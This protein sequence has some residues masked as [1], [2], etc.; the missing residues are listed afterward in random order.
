MPEITRRTFVKGSAVAVGGTAI[1]SKFLFGGL[2]TVQ[3]TN[4]LLMAQQ[5]QEDFVN[6]T[7]WIGKQDC[8]IVARRVNGRL[9]SLEGLEA[10]PKNRGTLC[11]KGTAQIAAVYDP[12]RIKTPLI[13]T[14]GKGG[15]GEFRAASWD[16]ALDLVASK[17]KAV[18]EED[19]KL[20]LW[21]KGRSK[22]KVF[23]DTAFV[24]ATGATKLGHGAYCSDTGYRAA[25]YTLGPHGV[26][27]PDFKYTRYLLSWG[28]NITAA[29]GNKTCWITWPQQMVEAREKNG[30]KIIQIDPRLRPAGHFADRWLPI[31]PS[32][33]LAFAL[34]LCRELIT[35]GFVDEPYLKAYTNSAHLVGPDGLILRGDLP[36]DAEEG[37]EAPALVWDQ[38]SGQAVPHDEAADPA[39]T[40]KYDVDGVAA[41]PAFQLFVENVEPYTPEWA[42]EICGLTADSI[43][44]VAAEF[45]ENANIGAT[46][47]VDGVEVP[48]RPVAIMAYHMAQQELGFQALRAMIMVS[49]LVGSP[50]AVGGQL[51]DFTWKIHKNY[52]KFG[53]LTVN[54]GP[55]DFTLAK[56]KFFPINSG[57]PGIVAKVMQDPAKYEVEKL[58]KVAI[59]HHVNPLTAFPSQKDFLDTYGKFEFVAVLSPWLSE[60]AD[61]FADVVLPTATMEKYEGPMSASDQY[62]DGKTLRLPVMDPLFESRGEIDIYIDLCERLGVLYGEGGYIDQINKNLPLKDEFALPLDQVPEVRDIFDRWSRMEGLEGGIEY[63]ERNGV[64]VKGPLPATKRYGY[65]TD[66][67]F[68]GALHRLYGESLLVA[69]KKQRELGADK[70]YWQDYT[71]LPTWRTPTMESS[72]PEYDLTLISYKLIEQKQSRTS[73]IPLLTELSGI[74]RLDM[75]PETASKLGIEEGD[76]VIVESHNAVTGETRQLRTVVAL[77]SGFRPDV[78]GM[79]HHFGGWSPDRNKGLGPS[80][81][82]IYYTGEG[83]MVCTADQSFHVKV[84]VLKG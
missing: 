55:Y 31:R 52:A 22:A 36:A 56:S 59:L 66:P 63:F 37:A 26:L 80:P 61:Y 76:D 14:N 35:L 2:E 23:Y 28:W 69:Q 49:M 48:Y 19:P 65:V 11:P 5:I 43:R 62:I 51:V 17:T 10:H 58:P 84:R 30:L 7:C 79:P 44:K 72:P 18:L 82:E 70:I 1:A 67:P 54:E 77:T 71:A 41:K 39:L 53:N 8:G 4:T 9:V 40:G 46:I 25:E 47:V 20:L 21:Q 50:G 16:E 15:P 42:A 27:H 74:Q 24:K 60:T 3:Q 57:F 45:G 73:M 29:G 75:N 33:D 64:W 13:R 81:N 78:V 68:G 83:Y 32:T 6:T 12:Q 38:A 34:A